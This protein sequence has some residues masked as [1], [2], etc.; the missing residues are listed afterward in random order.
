VLTSLELHAISVNLKLHPLVQD[1]GG[2]TALPPPHPHPI[3]HRRRLLF[4]NGRK[5]WWLRNF[6]IRGKHRRVIRTWYTWRFSLEPP[7]PGQGL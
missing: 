3:R 1:V 4:A 7:L 5:A 6:P 2:G